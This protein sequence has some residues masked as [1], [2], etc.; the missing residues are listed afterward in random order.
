M[1]AVLLLA[2][3]GCHQAGESGR[4][5]TAAA[6]A[7]TQ[8]ASKIDSFSGPYRFLSNFWP[9]KV[10]FEGIVYPSAEHAYQSA[11]TMDM[12]ERR[13]IAAITEPGDAKRAGRALRQR[14][15]WEAV[16]LSV[17]ETCVR[18]KFTRN[19]DLRDKLLGTGDAYLEEG[20]TWNDRFWG[21]CN[22]EGENHLGKILMNVRAEL[23]SGPI[24]EPRP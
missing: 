10:E 22:G 19:A 12:A 8:P 1:A 2:E 11:K 18:D 3:P 13:R 15:D 14:A 20:N 5:R 23:R 9:A 6:W 4:P 16:K 21:V 7:A 17:M 24:S